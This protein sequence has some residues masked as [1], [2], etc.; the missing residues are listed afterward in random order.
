[1]TKRQIDSQV[2]LGATIAFISLLGL[3]MGWIFAL[4]LLCLFI[5]IIAFVH[6]VTDYYKD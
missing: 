2:F 4:M 1:M 6:L 5:A 3:K